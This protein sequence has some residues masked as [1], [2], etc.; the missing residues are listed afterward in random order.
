VDFL[1]RQI[2]ADDM[3]QLT[4]AAIVDARQPAGLAFLDEPTGLH[5]RQPGR[6]RQSV[7]AIARQQHDLAGSD[8]HRRPLLECA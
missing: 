5:R 1:R 2:A 7:L 8:L 3:G 4:A 6:A